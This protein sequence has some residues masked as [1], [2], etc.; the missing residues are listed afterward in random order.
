[1]G[2]TRS[3][4]YKL[5]GIINALSSMNTEEEI[6][7]YLKENVEDPELFSETL[8]KFNKVKL[9]KGKK[10]KLP[11]KKEQEYLYDREQVFAIFQNNSLEDIVAKTSKAELAAMYYAVYCSKPLSADNKERIAQAIRGYIYS[12]SRAEVLLGTL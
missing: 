9:G 11:A 6:N 10:K 5:D 2:M 8:K 12:M 7:Q 4:I 3:E 1:M